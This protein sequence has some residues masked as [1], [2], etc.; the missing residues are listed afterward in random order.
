MVH[1]FP[2]N[3]ARL[4]SCTSDKRIDVPGWIGR[5]VELL[6]ESRRVHGHSRLWGH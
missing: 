2:A 5:P 6:N 4:A 1:M 3:R